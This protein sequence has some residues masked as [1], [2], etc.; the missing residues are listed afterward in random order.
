MTLQRLDM[1][2]CLAPWTIKFLGCGTD[3]SLLLMSPRVSSD[4]FLTFF[5]MMGITVAVAFKLLIAA[6]ALP[7]TS[8]DNGRHFVSMI[9]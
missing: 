7:V 5:T 3:D 1:K 6:T 4:E 8:G 2:E 9:S